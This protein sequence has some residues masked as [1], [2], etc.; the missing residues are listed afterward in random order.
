MSDRRKVP[1]IPLGNGKSQ[2]MGSPKKSQKH[3][4]YQQ[5]I[6]DFESNGYGEESS[7]MS[8]DEVGLME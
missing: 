1:P 5:M 2:N 4:A 6:D 3:G 7:N 8:E